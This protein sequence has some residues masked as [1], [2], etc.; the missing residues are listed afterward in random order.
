MAEIAGP[1]ENDSYKSRCNKLIRKGICLWDVL[2]SSKRPGSLDSAID[3][4]SATGNDFSSLLEQHPEIA[5]ICFNGKKSRE[6]FDRLV[7]RSTMV[8]EGC[9]LANL[10]SS[11]PAHAAMNFDQK[12]ERWSIIGQYLV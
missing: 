4:A 10:P 7:L 9:N 1:G 11:S 5:L 12:L 8:P 3:M 6:L 2:A